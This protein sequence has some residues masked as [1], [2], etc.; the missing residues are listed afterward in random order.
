[1]R[2]KSKQEVELQLNKAVNLYDSLY[3]IR[4]QYLK[5]YE[6]LIRKESLEAVEV[7]NDLKMNQEMMNEVA[8]EIEVYKWILS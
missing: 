1:M 7:D 5:K 8:K 4:K 2:M 6:S 3:V